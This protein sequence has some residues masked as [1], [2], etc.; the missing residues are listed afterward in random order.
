ME[1]KQLLVT[2]SSS[3]VKGGHVSFYVDESVSECVCSAPALDHRQ[4]IK[5][6]RS[7]LRSPCVCDPQ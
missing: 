4:V 2:G 7:P 3:E 6:M 5:N 1:C